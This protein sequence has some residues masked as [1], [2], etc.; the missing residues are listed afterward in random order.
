MKQTLAL[1]LAIAPV[2]VA[3]HKHDAAS[4]PGQ[5]AGAS[6]D[7]ASALP[8]PPPAVAARAENAPR[9]NV[10]GQADP[11]LTTQLR[12]FVKN[13]GRPPTSFAE[14]KNLGLDSI[15]EPPPGTKWVIDRSTTSV[16]AIPAR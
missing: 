13:Q 11:F 9:D 1:A 6:A 2:L 10:E 5:N 8:P 7:A 12:A 4:P 15:P 14:F 16:K 3:C